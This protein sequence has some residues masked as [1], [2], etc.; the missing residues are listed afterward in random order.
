MKPASNHQVPHQE[1]LVAKIEDQALA[2]MA[3]TRDFATDEFVERRL[4]AA[5]QEWID[6]EE[7]P[8]RLPDDAG[9]QRVRI[10]E[11]VRKFGHV[12]TGSRFAWLGVPEIWGG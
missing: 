8:Q 2:H 3:D 6:E 1:H 5:Q 9:P 11:D 4:D 10:R 7:A 12:Q